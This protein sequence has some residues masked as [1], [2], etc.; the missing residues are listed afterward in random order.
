MKIDFYHYNVHET[1]NWENI[2][3]ALIEL[4]ADAQ[5]IVE[6]PGKNAFTPLTPD[7]YERMINYLQERNYPCHSQP[8]Y[9]DADAAITTQVPNWLQHYK[10]LKINV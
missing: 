1:I 10:G 5:L 7:G 3:K 6:P 8:R 4:G 2:Y 9:K